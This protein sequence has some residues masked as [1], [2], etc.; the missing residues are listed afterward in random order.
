LANTVTIY[1]TPSLNNPVLIEGLPGIGFVANIVTLHLI[2]ECKPTLFGAI[3]SSSFQD[4]AITA[5]DGEARFLTN[6][7]YY[8][9]RETSTERDL[10]IYYGN[11]QALTGFGQYELC[12]N[13]LSIAHNL[14]CQYIVTLGGLRRDEIQK[15]PPELYCAASDPET[16]KEALSLGA[17]IIDGQI[18]G[19]AGL[20]IGLSTLWNMRG[21]CLLG[22]TLG[23]QPDVLAARKIAD[24]L[25][26]ML[27]LKLDMS[28]LEV[29]AEKTREILEVFGLVVSEPKAKT[30]EE[31]RWH[32]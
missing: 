28:Q 11:T 29:A 25:Y 27:N 14:G 9:K 5:K 1:E 4:L 30:R 7:L 16:L 3:H 19:M 12:G 10:I 24:A 18:F 22:E 6:E 8:L 15:V 32:I 20:M 31:L 26:K 23:L 21:F 13:I 17:K 2:R